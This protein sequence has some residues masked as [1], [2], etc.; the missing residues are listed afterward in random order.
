MLRRLIDLGLGVQEV[1]A[2]DR[3]QRL[4]RL[5]VAGA[6]L[7]QELIEAQRR[8]L[9]RPG[10]RP[11]TRLWLWAKNTAIATPKRR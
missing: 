10:G 2:V 6:A 4:L 5:S 8:L 7:L 3:R 9:R 1:G 11:G